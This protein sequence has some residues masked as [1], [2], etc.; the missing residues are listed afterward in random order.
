MEAPKLRIV[1]TTPEA[2]P[3]AE[4]DYRCEV[5]VRAVIDSGAFAAMREAP[6]GSTA[7]VVY[8]ALARRLPNVVPSLQR[9]AD[10]TGMTRRNV[11]NGIRTLEACGLVQSVQRRTNEG[12]LDASMYRLGDLRESE[13]VRR[14]LQKIREASRKKSKRKQGGV[15][16]EF[17]TQASG[18]VEPEFNT[19]VEPEFPKVLNCS[20]PKVAIEETNKQQRGS[21]AAKSISIDEKIPEAVQTELKRVGLGSALY[22]AEPGHPKAIPELTRDPG[23]GVAIIAQAMR[24]GEFSERA[25]VGA[26]VSHL[27]AKAAEAASVIDK[28]L[29][30]QKARDETFDAE[31]DAIIKNIEDAPQADLTAYSEAKLDEMLRRGLE[32]LDAPS[33]VK[34]RI[35]KNPESCH[36][37][38]V[39]EIEEEKLREEV[40]SMDDE[41]YS[42]L[43][44]A[45]LAKHPQLR[46]FVGSGNER[47]RMLISCLAEHLRLERWGGAGSHTSVLSASGT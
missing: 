35:A 22:L 19:G 37:I 21:A 30:D 24:S 6:Y 14:V 2:K 40:R 18:G 25:G 31:A 43:C 38:V 4:K 13:L 20:S 10:D 45:Y 15:E 39:K 8:M 16:P 41:A 12:D 3:L 47:G 36:R 23:R 17:N 46:R 28:R 26:R 5:A 29:A 11:V 32:R 44:E 27:R 42:E 7:Q 34:R 1:D 9:I 33:E